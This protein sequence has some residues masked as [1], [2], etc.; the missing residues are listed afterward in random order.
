MKGDFSRWDPVDGRNFNGVLHQQG[1]VLLD[2]DWNDQARL[3]SAWQD[4][5]ARDIIGPDVLAAS[6]R[7]P[8]AF[9]VEEAR[10]VDDMVELQVHPG[11]AWA[12]GLAVHLPGDPGAQV[13]RTAGYLE[14][15]VQDPA[16]AVEEIDAGFRDAVILEVWREALN[17]FQV[18]DALIEP[19]LGGPDTT[20]RILTAMRFR[21]F[22][23]ADGETCHDIIDQLTDDPA[24][25]GTLT[26]SLLPTEATSG[27]CPTVEGGGYTG[28]EHHLYRVEMARV[29]DAGQSWF[30]WSAFNGG[31]VGRGRVDFSDPTNKQFHITANDQ[32]IKHSGLTDFYLEV[33]AYDE[34]Q[35][36][37]RVTY[38]AEVTRNGDA[39]EVKAEH[40]TE[41]AGP[42]GRVFFRLWNEIRPIVEFA[43]PAP[44][45]DPT[46][47]RDGIRLVFHDAPG[48]NRRPGD[49][50]TFEVRAGEIENAGEVLIDAASPE[51]IRF[52]R[53]PLAEL[54]WNGPAEDE[55]SL[56]FDAG[57]IEDCREIFRP[58][59]DQDTCCTFTVGDGIQSRGDFDSIEEALRHLPADG[60]KI[61][62]LPGVHEASVAITGRRQV[63]I[64]GC[65]ARSVVQPRRDRVSEP[66]FRIEVSQRIQIDHLRMSAPAGIAIQI[67]D[68]A[69]AQGAT[70]DVSILHNEIV[71]CVQAVDVRINNDRAGDNDLRIAHNRIGMLDKPEGRAA[72]FSLADGVLIERNRIVVVPPPDPDDPD[73]PRND[74]DDPSVGI[75]DPCADPLLLYAPGFRIHA[76]FDS[77]FSY[78]TDIRG[79][80]S[81]AARRITHQA[82]GGIQ[83]GGGS[84]RVR[85]VQNEITGGRGNGISLGHIPSP[86]VERAV[87]EITPTFFGAAEH[88]VNVQRQRFVSFLYDVAIEENAIRNMGLSGIGVVAYFNLEQADLIVRLKELAIVRN[89]IT[90]CALHLPDVP[91]EERDRVGFGGVALLD[92]Q[93]AVIRDNRI[94]DNGFD[95][96]E[97][98][99][100]VYIRYGERIDVSDNRIVNNGPFGAGPIGRS[101][102]GLR[103]GVYVGMSTKADEEV[104]Q[105][106][107]DGFGGDGVPAVKIHDNIVTQ[108]L[109][110]ALVAHA[111]GPISVANN[112]LT[113]QGA[114]FRVNPLA[115][116]AAAVFILNLGRTKD[117]LGSTGKLALTHLENEQA[118]KESADLATAATGQAGLLLP[119]GAVLFAGNRTALDLRSEEVNIAIS[120][121][122]IVSLDDVAFNNNQS[123]CVSRQDIVLAN[124]LLI[125]FSVRSNDNRFQDGITLVLFSLMSR[126][127][128]NTAMSNQSTHCLSVQGNPALTVKEGNTV[129]INARCSDATD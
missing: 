100:G 90:N 35:G 27:D 104:L 40:Y 7:A 32:A 52:H 127:M 19:A 78:V 39:L 14:P 29:N 28:F 15:P 123:E 21:L 120:A 71:A 97:P 75:F 68:P 77:I 66:I 83:L 55:P 112:H 101:T 17:G 98:I 42:S 44:G 4:H 3:V 1:R 50:W 113:T 122:A 102:R 61:C 46:E 87:W 58:L 114:D 117:G 24:L 26:V 41:P 64:S 9:K 33:V 103:A 74:P 115:L 85:I 93:D 22:R 45:G 94:E 16:A 57:E 79:L 80:F 81:I 72:I 5:A 31:L 86:T 34:A 47:L 51:G 129:L 91:D 111:L 20:E 2:R 60:G 73:D 126:G 10:V 88:M 69:D 124:T 107:A 119:S 30:K 13:T 48:T 76:Y 54:H 84:E 99:C 8:L 125:G 70:Q 62:V 118:Y 59:V 53:V 109:G 36:F 116:L 89:A 56:N 43:E 82:H 65:G 18:P 96:T 49:Y 128:M 95:H 37:W 25:Q 92:C 12:D 105:G 121:Q 110:Q 6:A 67:A 11:L 63:R 106:D 38:G 108:P 23:L